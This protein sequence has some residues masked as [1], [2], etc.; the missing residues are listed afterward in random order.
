VPVAYAHLLYT[1]REHINLVRIL[2]ER[3]K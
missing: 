1:L 2:L 3:K